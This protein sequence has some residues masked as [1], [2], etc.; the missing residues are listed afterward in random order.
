MLCVS[1]PAM[2]C[3]SAWLPFLIEAALAGFLSLGR[4]GRHERAGF[5]LYGAVVAAAR[6]PYLFANLGIPDTL[7]GRFDSIGTE[8]SGEPPLTRFAAAIMSRHCTIRI[9][10][11]KK[12]MGYKPVLSVAEGLQTM[13]RL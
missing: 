9:D 12:D 11:I 13:P 8:L 2:P 10:K 4:K 7:D 1:R 5:E 6:D 3:Q